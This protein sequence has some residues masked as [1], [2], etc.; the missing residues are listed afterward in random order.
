MSRS[1]DLGMMKNHRLSESTEQSPEVSESI[2]HS[3]EVVTPNP[4]S[5][6]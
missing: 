1:L 4:Y 5:P 6:H 3:S 2:K